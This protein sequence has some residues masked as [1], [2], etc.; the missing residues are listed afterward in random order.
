MVFASRCRLRVVPGSSAETAAM[1]GR[2][3]FTLFFYLNVNVT[4][5]NPNA[6]E[7]VTHLSRCSLSNDIITAWIVFRGSGPLMWLAVPFFVYRSKSFVPHEIY[8]SPPNGVIWLRSLVEL[9]QMEIAHTTTIT[10]P[11]FLHFDFCFQ[12]W[13]SPSCFLD[14]VCVPFMYIETVACKAFFIV[15]FNLTQTSKM[16]S[17]L[18]LTLRSF[19]CRVRKLTYRTETANWPEFLKTPWEATAGRLWLPMSAPR[20]SPM[21]ILTTHWSTPTGLKRSNQRFV[22]RYC[23]EFIKS[24]L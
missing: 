1:P 2:D 24:K 9:V 6:C 17:L 12:F 18:V 15:H 20:P 19:I 22:L 3:H 13:P 14:S 10:H 5:W 8:C 16:I 7:T 4:F 21:M 23:V 11:S